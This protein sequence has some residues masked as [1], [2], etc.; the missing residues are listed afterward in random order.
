MTVNTT[1]K[2]IIGGIILW[3]LSWFGSW[4]CLEVKNDET[5]AQVCYIDWEWDV[6]DS[7]DNAK[8]GDGKV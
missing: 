5:T 6:A 4:T 1:D 2:I 7:I 8:K 3:L